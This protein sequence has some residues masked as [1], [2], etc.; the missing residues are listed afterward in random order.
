METSDPWIVAKE[1]VRQCQAKGYSDESIKASLK[2]SGWQDQQLETLFKKEGPTKKKRSHI[3]PIVL[4]TTFILIVLTGAVAGYFYFF[5]VSPTFVKEPDIQKPNMEYEIIENLTVT[6]EKKQTFNPYPEHI[7]YVLNKL[8]GY[9]LHESPLDKAMP[10]IEVFLSDTSSR[11]SAKVVDNDVTTEK[12]PADDPDLR[13]TMTSKAL[14]KLVDAPDVKSLASDYA[15]NKTIYLEVLKDDQILAL[16]GYK[17][18]YDAI[19]E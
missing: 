11:Y 1:Y 17:A 18:I 8:D 9:K 14:A 7:S 4:F 13:I 16:K 19:Q 5:V 12:R 6:T 15:N 3:I 2:N 10:E